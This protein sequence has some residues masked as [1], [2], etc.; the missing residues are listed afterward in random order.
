MH[1]FHDSKKT[2]IQTVQVLVSR[3]IFYE[4]LKCKVLTVNP[5][6][7]DSHLHSMRTCVLCVAPCTRGPHKIWFCSQVR[8]R[9]QT[10]TYVFQPSRRS[11][12]LLFKLD[13]FGRAREGAF[14]TRNGLVGTLGVRYSDEILAPYLKVYPLFR[15]VP[16]LKLFLRIKFIT[17]SGLNT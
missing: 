4:G 7:W 1:L 12:P 9:R 13:Y 15:V 10:P 6:A 2:A 11:P 5:R 8:G 16:L 14:E 17:K 3:A